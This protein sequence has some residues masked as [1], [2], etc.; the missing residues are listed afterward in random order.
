MN[1]GFRYHIATITAIFFA[2]AVGIVIGSSF[3]QSAI[4]DR[5][6]R[7]LEDLGAQFNR[8]VGPLREANRQYAAFV[9]QIA[10]ALVAN[11]LGGIRVA[12]VQTGDYPDTVRR[13]RDALERAGAKVASETVIPADFLQQVEAK[14][15]SLT[16]RLTNHEFVADG[17]E[18][19]LKLLA[20]AL[21]A[22]GHQ[23]DV[24][25]LE[26]EGI[27]MSE[28]DYSR[29]V[30]FVVVVGGAT[31]KDGIRSAEVD[32]PLIQELRSLVSTVI[33]AEPS[34]AEISYVES[35]RGAEIPTVDNAETDIGA[36]ALVM[37]LQ[38]PSGDYG[39]KQTARSG[40]LPAP[41]AR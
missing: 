35:L 40:L 11:K 13:V 16:A 17:P 24:N 29:P 33:A 21:G 22:P 39:V 26:G 38:G 34:N 12:L 41:A 30:S 36:V 31:A 15:A 25:A 1:P 28:G 37:A 6:T 18:G 23:S 32:V 8:E 27:V 10:P 20:E 9:E 3:V 5:H 14:K 4:V 7:R 19:V 2:L